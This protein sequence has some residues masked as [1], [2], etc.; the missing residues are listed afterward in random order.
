VATAIDQESTIAP[1]A[2]ERPGMQDSALADVSDSVAD[3]V[4]AEP[5]TGTERQESREADGSIEPSADVDVQQPPADRVP[6]AER[7]QEETRPVFEST[8][9]EP[10]AAAPVAEHEAGSDTESVRGD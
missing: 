10:T 2:P 1:P 9:P 4:S 3:R 6:V 7:E 5:E 8:T